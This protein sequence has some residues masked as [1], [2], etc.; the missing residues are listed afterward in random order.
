MRSQV[1][2]IIGVNRKKE[3]SPLRSR[4]PDVKPKQRMG[5]PDYRKIRTLTNAKETLLV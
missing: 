1:I 3:L 4:A 5:L 2:R